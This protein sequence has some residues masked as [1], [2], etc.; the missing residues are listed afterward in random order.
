MTVGPE[1]FDD[2]YADDPDPWG[3][4]SRWYERRKYA[5][6]LASLP[7]ERYGRA[8]EPGCSIGVLTA[9]LAERVDE[10]VAWEPHPQAAGRAAARLRS[11]PWVT[12][13]EASI[14]DR[15]PEGVFDL[16]VLS[17]VA[18]Y[19][20]GA[21]FTRLLERLDGGLARGGDLVA[22]HFDGTTDYPRS[23]AEVHGSLDDVV[24]HEPLVSHRD[25]GFLLDVWRRA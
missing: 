3:F 10:L 21:A 24:G 22:V 18:Y 7:L 13:E 19:L 23:A 15:W 16:V 14:P 4:E 17:E 25:E 5:V 1:Y 12:V 6:T 8:F 20:D 11:H 9:L 2:M